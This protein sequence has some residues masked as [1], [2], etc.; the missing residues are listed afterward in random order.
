MA[1]KL[2]AQDGSPVKYQGKEVFRFDY[3][4]VI[5]A[6]DV[7]RRQL[8]MIGTDETKDRDGDIIRMSGWN[9]DN[10]K[11]NPVFLWAHNYGSV[12]LARAEKVIKRQNPARMEF[13]LVFPTKSIYPFADM[14]LE[15]YGE[16]IINTSSVGFIPA[17]WEPHPVDD[18]NKEDNR[19]PYGR[20]YT[21]QELLEL[22]GCAVPSN[23]NALQ[24]ALKGRSF[25]FKPDDLVK[26]LAGATLIPRPENED[27]VLEEIDK[28]EIEIVDETTIQIQVPDNLAPSEE[29]LI[30]GEEGL[31]KIPDL[32]KG[33]I[34]FIKE[35]E[36]VFEDTEFLGDEEGQKPYP[37]EHA[38][39]ILEPNFDGYARKNCFRKV[40]DKCVDYIFGIR[41]NKSHLQAL[42]FKKDIWTEEAAKGVCSRVG[43]KF[44]AAKSEAI[45]YISPVLES[46]ENDDLSK[47]MDMMQ[48]MTKLHGK[49]DTMHKDMKKMMEMMQSLSDDSK[50]I[51]AS[52]TKVTEEGQRKPDIGE[53]SASVILRNA[54]RQ[55][56]TKPEPTPK[57]S[58]GTKVG[59]S[60]SPESVQELK[61]VV[62]DF[63]KAVRSIKL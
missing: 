34:D 19:N 13:Q 29:D 43:G 45:E 24:N 5:K 1:T 41:D 27:D 55:S 61:R 46:T 14:I 16:K 53:D 32:E 4:G 26:Y 22:S 33:T 49:M 20:I 58:D 21:S 7:E 12:P 18:N 36:L 48:M 23:P 9:L 17:K 11:K 25:G 38:C 51:Q 39:R 63:A 30:K 60:Y 40:N 31:I 6:V 59:G 10:Y 8:T 57:P 62:S 47:D 35:E 3:A 42:R 54:Y 56:K 44:E 50:G 28:A 15:L 2:L 37:N 52:L